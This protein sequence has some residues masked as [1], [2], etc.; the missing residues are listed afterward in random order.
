MD[1]LAF[2][3]GNSRK[4]IRNGIYKLALIIAAAN[5]IARSDRR[6]PNNLAI[7]FARR[8]LH[9]SVRLVAQFAK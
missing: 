9:G 5:R 8:S 4:V 7:L 3:P 1:Y 6:L 2:M